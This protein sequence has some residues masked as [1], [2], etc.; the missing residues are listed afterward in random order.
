MNRIL[1]A[2]LTTFCF[3]YVQAQTK[4]MAVVS[5][6]EK[7]SSKTI[8]QL[9]WFAGDF[10]AFKQL[11]NE[12][13]TVERIEISADQDPKTANFDG[14]K[15]TVIEPTKTRLNKL[16]AN[17][18]SAQ[19]ITSL[20]DPFL[21]S[22]SPD[23]EESKNFA[24][25]LAVL[26]CSISKETGI[27]IGCTYTDQTAEKGKTYA[28]R[29]RVKNAPDGFI[30]VQTGELTTY[31]KI[32]NVTLLLDRKNTVELRWQARKT[33]AFGYGFQLEK[34][35]DSPKEGNYLTQTP[36]VPVRSADEKADKDDSFRDEQLTEGKTHFYR[37][38]GLNYFGEAVMYS[39]W[40]KIYIPN[41]V[42]AEIYIDTTY[43]KD[44]NRVIEGSA[45]GDGKPMNINR[46]ELHQSNQKDSD[47]TLIEKK[48]YS[49]SVFT[50]TVPMTKTGDQFYYKV[51]AISKDNDTVSSLPSYV[52]TLDQEPPAKPTL[53]TGEIDSNGVVRLSWQA[54]TDKDLKGYRIY[55]ANDKR[56]EFKE[57]NKDLSMA[58]TLI[59]TIRLDNLTSEVYYCVKAVD[60]NFNNSPFSDTILVLKPDTIA[61][62]PAM[63]SKPIVN[64]SILILSWI[65]SPSVDVK[66]NFLIRQQGIVIDTL[67]RWIAQTESYEDK[68]IIAGTGYNYRIV[69]ADKSSNTS[70]SEPRQVYYEPGYRK[71]IS[72]AKAVSNKSANAIDLTWSLP[73]GE[74]F[75]FQIYKST[76][77]GKFSLLKTIENATCVSYSDKNVITGVKYAYKVKYVLKSG[78]HGMPTKEM[79]VLF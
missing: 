13:S 74:I 73:Q 30:V 4:Q 64:D 23:N 65:N 57:R 1:L 46:Y 21:S 45:Y 24:F 68:G 2:L 50:F 7:Q 35:L 20:L 12:G 16:D 49:D 41:H 5:K 33:K 42:H 38:V 37:V 17:T 59:D 6:V 3:Q 27:V 63:L 39:E 76:D 44:Q 19:R 9:K 54:P 75:S 8:V 48:T 51:L 62:V 66:M 32:E 78:I 56:E 77:G 40:Q 28:Y 67:T 47:Y 53:L 22:N 55:R 25:A 72:E 26:D 10:D 14:A 29:I 60:L 11:V 31:P 79:V 71:A 18:E 36:Y 69:T 58:T 52:F 15:K 34:S 70:F 61:P 43:A